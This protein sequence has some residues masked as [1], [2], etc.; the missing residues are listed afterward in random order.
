MIIWDVDIANSAQQNSDGTGEV[1]DFSPIGYLGDKLGLQPPAIQANTANKPT[2]KLDANGHMYAEFGPA[3]SFLKIDTGFGYTSNHTI[4]LVA[5]VPS[6]GLA[7]TL[8]DA[9]TFGVSRNWQVQW[10]IDDGGLRYTVFNASSYNF[11]DYDPAPTGLHVIAFRASST[12]GSILI[13]GV[14]VLD[15]PLIGPCPD[16]D[17]PLTIGAANPSGSYQLWKGYLYAL[18]VSNAADSDAEVAS[19]S[20]ALLSYYSNPPATGFPLSFTNHHLQM[21]GAR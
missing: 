4:Y 5:N 2:A 21:M 6:I 9:D 18:Q 15:E 8:L 11:L 20:A 16:D 12:V 1:S 17:T 3:A 19:R 13:D 7:G 14:N 10:P